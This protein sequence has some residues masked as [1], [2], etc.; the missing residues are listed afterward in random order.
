VECVKSRQRPSSDIEIGHRSTSTCLLANVAYRS[1][2]KIVWDVAN[3]RLVEGG[4][5]A[6]K[7]LVREYRAP[8]K[9]AV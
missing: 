8:W 4:A 7:L 6:K 9:L 1:Q 5:D 2:E 3:Q